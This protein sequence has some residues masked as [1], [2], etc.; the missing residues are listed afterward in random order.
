MSD[1]ALLRPGPVLGSYPEREDERLSTL[2]RVMAVASGWL[3]QRFT[4]P[5]ADAPEVLSR[6]RGVEKILA[7]LPAHELVERTAQLRH[8][9]RTGGLT[10]EMIASA[11]GLICLVSDRHLG[12]RPY[13]VQILGGLLMLQGRIAEMDTGEGKTLT[14][15]LPAATAAL[16]GAPVHVITVNDYLA[17]RDADWMRPVYDALGLT[18]GVILENMSPDE[19]RR[20][21]SADIVYGSNKQMA[22]DYLKDRIVLGDE[23]RPL[24]MRVEDL[25]SNEPRAG[26]LLMRGLCFAIVDEAD[27][28]L[29]DEARTPLI[30][31]KAGDTSGM[32]A[33]YANA[34]KVAR[35]LKTP[36]DF[37]ILPKERRVRLTDLGRQQLK[38]MTETWGSVWAAEIHREELGRQALSALWL[39]ERDKHY[40]VRDGSIAIVDEYTGRVMADRSWERGLHQMIEIKEGLEVTGRHETLARISYQ[41]FFRR[42][43]HVCGMTGTAHEVAGELWSVYGLAVQRVPPNRPSRRRSL[44]MEIYVTEEAKLRAIV[45]RVARLHETGTPVLIGT[46]LVATSETLSALLHA[47]DLPHNVLNANQERDEA[48]VVAQAGQA[49]QIT[50]ATNMA[51]RG[52]DIS[53]GT[54]LGTKGGLFVIATEPHDARRIDRQLYGRCG[55][56]GD[57]G[58]HMMVASLED[59]I[60]HEA[61]GDRLQSLGNRFAPDGG[62]VPEKVF[63]PALAYAQWTAERRNSVTRRAL[64][65]HD[66][67]LE[68]MLAFAGRAE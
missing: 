31:S 16:A 1:L 41:R 26:K 60:V 55:R 50:V 13:D 15:T 58:T 44:G 63:G 17:A 10:T 24:H 64:L 21:Y 29:I 65:R 7:R 51:G 42:Y 38:K 18:V 20:A 47:A 3:R 57:R 34:I 25:T 68:D 8:G 36:R 11:F 52:T 56:Q 66:D 30:I 37:N 14:A 46:R 43:L 45:K 39:Y 22:F 19:R 12:L 54:G 9:L 2:D 62:R 35:K 28:C 5:R 23:T 33:V 61:F 4:R 59:E 27:S 40:I 6:A 49:G 32:E 67:S 53:L 48:E